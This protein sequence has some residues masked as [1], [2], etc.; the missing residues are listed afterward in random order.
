MTRRAQIFAS[1]FCAYAGFHEKNLKPPLALMWRCGMWL[2][3]KIKQPQP[4]SPRNTI[5]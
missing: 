1:R 5:A 2:Q 3:L 4:S